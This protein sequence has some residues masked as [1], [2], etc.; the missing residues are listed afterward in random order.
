M[1][2]RQYCSYH[3]AMTSTWENPHGV[4]DIV[5]NTKCE[6][7][8]DS[9]DFIERMGGYENFWENVSKNFV[10]HLLKGRTK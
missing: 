1:D 6:W 9:R 2:K 7:C 5:E 8:K 10:E 3:N 4:G